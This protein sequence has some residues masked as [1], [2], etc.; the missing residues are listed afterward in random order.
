[1]KK[2]KYD[3]K[4]MKELLKSMSGMYDLARVV[5]PIECRI[6]E[7]GDDGSISMQKSC[8]GIWNAEQKCANCSSAIACKTGCHQEKSELFKDKL[9]KI[10][11]NPIRLKLLDGTFYDAAIELVSIKSAAEE[12]NIINNRESENAENKSIQYRALYDSLTGNLKSDAFFEQARKMLS[13]NKYSSWKIVMSDVKDYRFFSSLFGEEK[14]N[15]MLLKIS[16]LLKEIADS[17]KGICSRLYRDRFALLLPS[18]NYNE[19]DLVKATKA[20]TDSFNTGVYTL[21]VQ[22]GIYDI[23]NTDMPISVMCDR[24]NMALRKLSGSYNGNIAYF[25]DEIMQKN[26]NEQKIISGFE[27]ALA[28]GRI[29]MYLQPLMSEDGKPFGAEALARWF[30][31]EGNLISPDVFIEILENAGLIYKLDEYMWEQAVKQLDRW[32]NTEKNKLTISVNISAKDFYSIDVYKVLTKLTKKYGVS[33]NRLRLEITESTLIE[34]KESIYPVISKLQKN[35]FL[36][37]IDDFGKGY[38]SLSL[39]KDINADIL[40]I[41]MCFLQEIDNEKRS[42]IILKS[43][44]SMA[45]ELEMQVI[46]EGVETE[47]QLKSLTDMGCNHFQGFYFSKPVPIEEFEIMYA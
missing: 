7:F 25:D 31:P 27:T 3:V 19:E 32:K 26:I 41:D 42:R 5:D 4:E 30:D 35:G 34:N 39:L 46:S 9:Y 14:C 17:D 2:A 47:L 15:E 16:E 18:E 40:K 24:A 28:E 22:F 20:I 12:K 21:R 11:S 33:P 6:L 29:R 45:K 37:E 1:M 43:I 10:Q 13:E 44:I 38:S 8:Y 36:V 23:T